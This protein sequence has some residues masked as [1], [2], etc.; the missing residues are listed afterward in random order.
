MSRS[1]HVPLHS[2]PFPQA[3][4]TQEIVRILRRTY[5]KAE[6]ALKHGSAFELLVST[7]L[8]AQ[9]TDVRVNLVT[10]ALFRRYPTPEA[11]AG[12]RLTDLQ[13]LI[14]PTGFF[15]SK[16]RALRGTAALLVKRFGGQVPRAM[17]EMLELPGVARKTANV[18]LG[19]WY[20]LSTGI[21]VDTHVF[22]LSHRLGLSAQRDPNKVERE[23]MRLIP[24]RYWIEFGHAMIWH[25]RRICHARKP[26]CVEC[27]LAHLCP[28]AGHWG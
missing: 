24:K 25:G 21:T 26:R 3:P 9:C 12:A 1:P 7:I 28:S 4:N 16:A 19:T 18:V 6:C 14:R 11:M 22:R 20:G 5:P 13:R 15:R 10:P 2:P 17:E 23:L 27:P 8:S